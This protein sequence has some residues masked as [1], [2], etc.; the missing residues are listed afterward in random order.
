VILALTLDA[1]GQPERVPALL[2][3]A[4]AGMACRGDGSAMAMKAWSSFWPRFRAVAALFRSR[5]GASRP[6][7]RGHG[8]SLH[9]RSGHVHSERTVSFAV[10]GP[11]GEWLLTALTK[12]GE[13]R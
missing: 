12:H 9:G 2:A 3:E 6:E 11:G 5:T 4:R 7:M 10:V 8:R 13:E 1:S